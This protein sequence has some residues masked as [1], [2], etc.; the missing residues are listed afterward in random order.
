MS[1]PEKTRLIE[2]LIKEVEATGLAEGVWFGEYTD[3][4]ELME[5]LIKYQ[6]NESKW[7]ELLARYKHIRSH[8]PKL[9]LDR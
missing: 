6:P 5:L 2:L 3:T 7:P 9:G 8:T 1:E 4:V